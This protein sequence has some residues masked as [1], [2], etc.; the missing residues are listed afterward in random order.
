MKTLLEFF[1][2]YFDFLYLDARYRITDSSTSGAAT[3]NAG[4]DDTGPVDSWSVDND[5]GLRGFGV[6]L[7]GLASSPDNWF[8]ASIIRHDV[9]G[10]DVLFRASPAILVTWTAY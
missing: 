8:G 4:L 5:G 7:T 9:D 2:E 1:I 3:I 10:F 6:A